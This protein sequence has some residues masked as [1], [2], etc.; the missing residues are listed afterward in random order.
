MPVDLLM[1]FSLQGSPESLDSS[2]NGTLKR[3][4]YSE[5]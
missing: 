1:R 4:G 3:G 2:L 5:L